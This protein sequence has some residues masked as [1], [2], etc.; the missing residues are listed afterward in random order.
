MVERTCTRLH[1][2]GRIAKGVPEPADQLVDAGDRAEVH[3]DR[4]ALLPHDVCGVVFRAVRLGVPFGRRIERPEHRELEQG[5]VVGQR[6]LHGLERR[7]PHL[8]AELGAML[9]QRGLELLLASLQLRD[10]RFAGRRVRAVRIVQ[11]E[12]RELRGGVVQPIHQ[13]AI[14]RLGNPLAHRGKDVRHRVL[15]A[16]FAL[17]QH[18]HGERRGAGVARRLLE[19]Q[20]KRAVGTLRHAA[21]ECQLLPLGTGGEIERHLRF[22]DGVGPTL[23]RQGVGDVADRR[24]RP[25]DVADRH[26]RPARVRAGGPLPEVQRAEMRL[27]RH[28]VVAGGAIDVRQVVQQ[29][30]KVRM[31]RADDPLANRQRARIVGSR[32]RVVLAL[33][34]DDAQVLHRRRDEV[35]VGALQRLGDVQR[36]PEE[37]LRR[38]VVVPL[39]V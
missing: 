12:A 34:G 26:Q 5:G 16:A 36:A 10:R 25:R 29:P 2:D 22:Q 18:E 11:H 24:K 35:G 6:G 8:R 19:M 37:R 14:G 32:G 28:R 7:R 15:Y 4:G 33:T 27:E 17:E 30:G 38:R 3:A 9:A 23:K 1:L 21:R 31:I 39:A 20:G 13:H